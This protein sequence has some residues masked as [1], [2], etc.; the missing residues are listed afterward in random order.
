MGRFKEAQIRAAEALQRTSCTLP[1]IRQREAPTGP[2]ARSQWPFYDDR[3]VSDHYLIDAA[4]AVHP[5]QDHGVAPGAQC[6]GSVDAPGASGQSGP[7]YY[8]S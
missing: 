6:S 1:P 3:G 8:L 4:F 5:L 7:D 2:F